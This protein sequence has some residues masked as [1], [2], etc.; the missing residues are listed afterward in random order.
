M[1]LN[2]YIVAYYLETSK[3]YCRRQVINLNRLDPGGGR[4]SV[5]KEPVRGR[6]IIDEGCKSSNSGCASRVWFFVWLIW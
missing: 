3:H 1:V 5:G 4:V 6:W 2:L